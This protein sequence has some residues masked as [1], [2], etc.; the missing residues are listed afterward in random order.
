M[1]KSKIVA[2]LGVIIIISLSSISI[3]ILYGLSQ[4]ITY[5]KE[6]KEILT[7]KLETVNSE[8]IITDENID[9]INNQIKIIS[10]KLFENNSK[11]E[12]L[13]SGKRYEL[14]D[15]TYYEVL[16]FLDSDKTN[17]KPYDRDT[18]NCGHYSMEVNN[19]SEKQGIRCAFVYINI[20]DPLL[21][22]ACVG[23]NTIDKGM[24]YFEPQNDKRV[25][26]EIGKDYWADCMTVSKGY[27][28][29]PDP[30]WIIIDFISIW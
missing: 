18:F 4:T 2:I 21:N 10:T 26:L 13:K 3:N 28:Y 17:K 29:K 12:L 16:N 15:P 8:L 7:N 24:V 20:T 27:Y 22:H 11:V 5:E 19:N 25:R 9:F 14:H 6:Q 30:D 1:N 23:F